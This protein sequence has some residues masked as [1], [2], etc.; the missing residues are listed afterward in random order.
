MNNYRD[1]IMAA[2]RYL[3]ASGA[4]GDMPKALF[5]YNHAVP[6]V[7]ASTLYADAMRMD[8]NTFRGYWRWQA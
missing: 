7:N 8:E 4:P 2:A 5:A 1:A 3:K 6:Y